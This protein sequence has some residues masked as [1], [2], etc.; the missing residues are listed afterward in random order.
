[1]CGT[2]C[3]W[4]NV[5]ADNCPFVANADQANANYDYEIANGQSV[6]G[7]ACDPVPAPVP[8]VSSHLVTSSSCA[9]AQVCQNPSNL[10]PSCP[11]GCALNADCATCQCCGSRVSDTITT[12]TVGSHALNEG[13]LVVESVEHDAPVPST[14]GRFCQEAVSPVKIVCHGFTGPAGSGGSLPDDNH[15]LNDDQ[16]GFPEPANPSPAVPWHRVT[17]TAFGSTQVVADYIAPALSYGDPASDFARVWQYQTDLTQWLATPSQPIIP[18]CASLDPTCLR[19]TWWN[20]GL[21]DIGK[22]I[23]FE[24]TGIH[25]V[26]AMDGNI[27]DSI[28]SIEPVHPGISWCPVPVPTFNLDPPVGSGPIGW[29][30]GRLVVVPRSVSLTLDVNTLPGASRFLVASTTGNVVAALQADGSALSAE[31]VGGADCGGN[32]VDS[33]LHASLFGSAVTWFGAVEP[34][35]AIAGLPDDALALSLDGARVLA[36]AR[37]ENGVLGAGSTVPNPN[38]DPPAPRGGYAAVYS[39]WAGGV[40]VAGG[41]ALSDSSVLRD[42]WFGQ[43]DGSW[44][45]VTPHAAGGSSCPACGFVREL[46]VV[47]AVTYSFADKKLWLVDEFPSK[48]FTVVRLLRAAPGGAIEQVATWVRAGQARSYFLA[49]DHDGAVLAAI[50][51]ANGQGFA[52]ARVEVDPSGTAHASALYANPSDKLLARPF[53]SPACYAFLA[54]RGKQLPRV[55]RLSHLERLVASKPM[56][57]GLCP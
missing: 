30:P 41:Q 16:I 15:V 3:S 37:T 38:G 14:Y 45:D 10:S 27:A 49:V 12:K 8:N 21:T 42:V 52:V 24:Q 57:G 28:S 56:N 9:F 46:G 31:D 26:G 4:Q 20:S 5:S 50:A 25:V 2:L 13:P 6:L 34:S 55:L 51:R 54:Q 29:G 40:F 33:A 7:D 39:R 35:N 36:T 44:R 23:D 17:T 19:G 47:D 18:G 1:M 53:V 22:T 43:L 32:S 48:P 11:A